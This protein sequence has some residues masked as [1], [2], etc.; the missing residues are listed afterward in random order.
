MLNLPR[1]QARHALAVAIGV[2]VARGRG[3]V[4]PELFE[5]AASGPRQAQTQAARVNL[6]RHLQRVKEKTSGG[7]A[8]VMRS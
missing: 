8:G 4:S 1:L 3:N 7:L 2:A 5:G 6:Q